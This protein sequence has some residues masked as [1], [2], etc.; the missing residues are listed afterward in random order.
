MKK[1]D[2][3]TN[4][5]LASRWSVYCNKFVTTI[6]SNI[7]KI[8]IETTHKNLLQFSSHA[9]A[10]FLNELKTHFTKSCSFLLNIIKQNKKITVCYKRVGML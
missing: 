7:R 9:K 3:F 10:Q 2:T 4:T 8:C 6:F 1:T 5:S